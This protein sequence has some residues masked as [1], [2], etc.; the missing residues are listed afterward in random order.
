MH[1]SSDMPRLIR[2]ACYSLMVQI[3][4]LLVSLFVDA[5]PAY[6]TSFGIG[7]AGFGVSL[8]CFVLYFIGELRQKN[9]ND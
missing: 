3:L 9:P 6:L 2:I 5:A 4:A 1:M 7:G 8:G